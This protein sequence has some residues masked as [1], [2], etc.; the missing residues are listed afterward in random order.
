M[1]R[2][3]RRSGNNLRP[4]D[5]TGHQRRRPAGRGGQ[6]DVEQYDATRTLGIF[7]GRVL[8]GHPGHRVLLQIYQGG[9]WVTAT[10]ATLS[11]SSSYTMA[12]RRSSAGWLLLRIAYPTQHTD[13]LWNVSRNLKATWS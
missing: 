3:G 5:L 4:G 13:H 9:K 12:Y 10:S 6:R 1:G 11:S 2:R 8:P 7:R